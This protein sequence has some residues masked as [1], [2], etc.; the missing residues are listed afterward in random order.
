M[1]F[2]KCKYTKTFA[3]IQKTL[4]KLEDRVNHNS[5]KSARAETSFERLIVGMTMFLE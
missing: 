5:N 1:S 4:T 2:H 3:E